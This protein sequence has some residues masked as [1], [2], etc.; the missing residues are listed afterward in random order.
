M[1]ELREVFTNPVV[2]AFIS[3]TAVFWVMKFA[4]NLGRTDGIAEGIRRAKRIPK[5]TPVWEY[6]DCE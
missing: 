1:N 4:Y 6:P 5:T 2:V 3:A